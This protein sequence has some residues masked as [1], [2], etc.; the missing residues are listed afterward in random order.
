MRTTALVMTTTL[1]LA[2]A[3]L[4]ATRAGAVYYLDER[5]EGTHFP[6]P[7]WKKVNNGGSWSRLSGPPPNL[8][9]AE[10]IAMVNEPSL[11]SRATPPEGSL[12]SPPLS[13][14]A[15]TTLYYRFIYRAM[16][17]ARFPPYC[18]FS[19]CYADNG[20]RF[21]DVFLDPLQYEWE[22]VSGSVSAAGGRTI[23]AVWRVACSSIPPAGT[24]FDIDNCQISDEVMTAVAPASLGRV[25]AIYR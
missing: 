2:S 13:V 3:L 14:P 16:M 10:G 24:I 23:L 19:I 5:F 17:A 1:L 8:A 4:G 22:E 7:G 25:K 11:W 21:V 6:P 9:Y 18:E 15:A 12:V 20:E